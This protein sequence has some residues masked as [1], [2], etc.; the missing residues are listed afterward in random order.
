MV[1]DNI[2]IAERQCMFCTGIILGPSK[3]ACCLSEASSLEKFDLKP[4]LCAIIKSDGQIAVT[5]RDFNHNSS[6]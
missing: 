5:Q 1:S 6:R 4:H 3:H 2:T